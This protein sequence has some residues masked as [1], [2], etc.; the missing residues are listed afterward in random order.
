MFASFLLSPSNRA[1][2]IVT[3]VCHNTAHKGKVGC[4]V[5]SSP[6]PA[7]D[8]VSQVASCGSRTRKEWNGGSSICSTIVPIT[9]VVERQFIQTA[10][11][12]VPVPSPIELLPNLTFLCDKKNLGRGQG[13][14]RSFEADLFFF[15]IDRA[16]VVPLLLLWIQD[17][18]REFIP[19]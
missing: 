17:H 2:A 9:W 4:Q 16:P 15:F 7:V 18:L 1:A 6:L 8:Q 12:R 11:L 5:L 14:Y 10:L 3:T 13:G 19:V